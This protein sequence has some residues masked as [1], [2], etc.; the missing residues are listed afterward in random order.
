MDKADSVIYF[1]DPTVRDLSGARASLPT[2]T[3]LAQLLVDRL[4]TSHPEL[5]REDLSA[6]KSGKPVVLKEGENLDVTLPLHDSTGNVIGAIGLT[7]RPRRGEQ[8]ADAIRRARTA[9]RELERQIPSKVK[10]F[11]SAG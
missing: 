6:M 4:A 5:I 9:A 3:T 10:L 7:F 1:D 8:K 11:D 2:K